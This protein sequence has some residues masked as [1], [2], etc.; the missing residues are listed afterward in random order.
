MNPQ[1]QYNALLIPHALSLVLIVVMMVIVRR[2]RYQQIML[3]AQFLLACLLLWMSMN[4]LELAT[5]NTELSLFFADLSFLGIAFIPVAWLSIV[6]VYLGKE[7]QLKR[8]LPVLIVIP[9]ATNIVIW[10]NQA[11]GWWRGDSYRDLTLTWFPVSFYDYGAWF[12][13]V[14]LPF[15]LFIAFSAMLL[16][17]RSNYM[18][19]SAFRNQ[20]ILLVGALSLPLVVEILHRFGVSPIPYYNASSLAFPVSGML[21]V[22]ALLR[23]RLFDLTPVARETLVESME[24]LMLVLDNQNRILDMNPSAHQR[25]FGEALKI[26][27]KPIQD[28]LGKEH[29][30]LQVVESYT[31]LTTEMKLYHFGEWRYY[32]VR[33]SPIRQTTGD[34][35]ARLIM[36]QDISISK[37][38]EETMMEQAQQ[39]AVLEERQRLARELHDSVNQTLF[40]ASTLA[41]L[42]PRAIEKK[43]ERVPEYTKNIRTLL[44]GTSAQMRLVLLELHPD[45]LVKTDLGVT[46]KHLA[47]AHTGNTGTP[48]DVRVATPIILPENAQ[49]V[50]YRIAQE[51]LHNINK[52]AQASQVIVTLKQDNQH[53][54]L[55]I[56]DD[57]VGFDM[58]SSTAN[59]HFGLANMRERAEDLGAQYS[60]ESYP[61]KGTTIRLTYQVQ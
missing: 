52:H 14:H 10:T 46:L 58:Q 50:F 7:W 53:I 5:L 18:R 19:Q 61:N 33:I 6:M 16:L 24:D 26:V 41:D 30:L 20:I 25:L 45:A 44:Q 13:F 29:P 31:Y 56:E 37:R 4:A 12:F 43:P 32:A 2:Q 49:L 15:S 3:S 35:M 22:V 17:L 48:V 47:D 11:H 54:T 38:T 34:L 8:W 21:V 40:A 57:G 59:D 51:A 1:W 55:S 60:L 39:V 28:V 42:L 36:L 23:Y 27:G 9:L